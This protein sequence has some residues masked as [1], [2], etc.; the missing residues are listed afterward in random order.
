MVVEA[1]GWHM[2]LKIKKV[3]T[4]LLILLTGGIW[5]GADAWDNG[6]AKTPPMGWNSW[7]C[8]HENINETQIREIADAMVSSGMRDAGYIYLILDD[9]WMAPF[10][11]ANGKLMA[12]QSR[13]PGGMKALGDYI[14]SKGLKFGIYGDRGLSTCHHYYSGPKGAESGSYKKEELDARTFAEWG[15]DYLKYDNCN[16]APG[17]NQQEDYERMRD[18]LAKCGRDI[19]FSICAWEFKP[20]MPKTGNLWRTTGDISDVWQSGPNDWFKGIINIIDLNEPLAP[21]AGPGAWNDPDM[22]QIGNGGCTVEEYRTHFTMWCIMAAPLIAGNDIRKMNQTIKDILL[23]REAI[24]VNQDSAGIQGTRIKAI[25][26]LEVWCKPLGSKNGNIKAVALLNRNST[27]QNIT[28]NFSDI[29]LS[30][31]VTVRDLWAKEDKGSFTG[32]YTMMVP[33]HGAGLLKITGGP[34]RSISAFTKIEA[35]NYS[36]Q[37]GIQTET[38]SEGGENLGFIENGDYVVYNNVDFGE[39][40]DG[41]VARVSSGSDGGIIEIYLDSLDGTPVGSCTVKNS[42]GWQIWSGVSCRVTRISGKHNVYLRFTGGESYL[43]N[44]N[45]FQFTSGTVGAINNVSRFEIKRVKAYILNGNIVIRPLV[46]YFK[47]K[48]SVF[49]PDGRLVTRKNSSA[50]VITIPIESNG[51]YLI[52]IEYN[53]HVEEKILTCF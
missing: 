5:R 2:I 10:R 51:I 50:D 3:V 37:S 32:S 42:G 24:A 8:F 12:D 52:K 17:S 22:L 31:E 28:V 53:G 44:I 33:S 19:V 18:A 29:G 34:P 49:M 45:W 11:D 25:N 47:F 26:D 21:Y 1:K 14:H 9:N 41:F 30:G 35:E 6:L 48:A 46:S 36:R 40:A 7:N 27:A 4:L 20:W 39:G 43:L 16:P 15:V 13:F 23:N 38:C